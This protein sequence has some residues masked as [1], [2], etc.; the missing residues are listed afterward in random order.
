MLTNILLDVGTNEVE[1]ASLRIAGA[2]YGL[3]AAKVREIVPLD[4]TSVTPVPRRSAEIRGLLL[5]RGEA[6]PLLDLAVMLGSTDPEARVAVIIEVSTVRC[7]IACHSMDRIHRLSWEALEPIGRL[8]KYG[9]PLIGTV[10]IEGDT[11]LLLDIERLLSRVFPQAA[12]Q[13][14][15]LDVTEEDRARRAGHQVFVA[16]DSNMIRHMVD[17]LLT[18]A[19]YDTRCFSNGAEAFA[20]IVEEGTHPDLLLSDIEMPQMDGLTLC[21]RLKESPATSHIPIVLFSSLIEGRQDDRGS[22]VNADVVLPKPKIRE[23]VMCTDELL[24]LSKPDSTPSS[25]EAV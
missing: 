9:S 23:V 10:E 19:G 8:A 4:P 18:E 22:R 13:N 15:S 21:R 20:A 2:R 12:L 5:H 14:V 7:A 6:L 16:E 25:P 3:N 1:I 17:Q 11:L 24:G